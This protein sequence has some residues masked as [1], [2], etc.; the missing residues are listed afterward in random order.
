MLHTAL[1]SHLLHVYLSRTV[2][3]V[4]NVVFFALSSTESLYLWKGICVPEM[5]MFD[6]GKSGSIFIISG[7]LSNEMDVHL[8]CSGTDKHLKATAGNFLP[9]QVQ[10]MCEPCDPN[11]LFWA[12][13]VHC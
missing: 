12:C 13:G 2:Q 10:F 3:I 8:P 4:P 11:V 6:T 7:Q 9:I 5:Y 1:L